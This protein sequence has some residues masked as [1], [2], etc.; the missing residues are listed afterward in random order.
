MLYNPIVLESDSPSLDDNPNTTYALHTLD[1]EQLGHD[2]LNLDIL[3]V[4]FDHSADKLEDGDNDGGDNGIDNNMLPHPTK[5]QRPT[6]PRYKLIYT[7]P[8][9]PNFYKTRIWKA[10]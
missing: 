10:V 9:H 3:P 6:S 8:A 1:S 4:C 7:V 5:R 2:A